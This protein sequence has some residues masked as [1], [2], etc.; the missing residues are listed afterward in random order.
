MYATSMNVEW[1]LSYR[2]CAKSHQISRVQYLHFVLDSVG[3]ESPCVCV[4]C[5]QLHQKLLKFLSDVKSAEGVQ[6]N[7][8]RLDV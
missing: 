3:Y 4:V 5:R 8:G 6:E 2:I 1:Y 7:I